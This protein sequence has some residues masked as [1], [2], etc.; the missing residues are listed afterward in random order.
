MTYF[1]ILYPIGR[2]LTESFR[3]DK[4]RGENILMGL[5][6]G[7]TISVFLIVIFTMIHLKKKLGFQGAFRE[8]KF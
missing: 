7:Q 5:S 3:G 2:F 1:F 8:A 4:F 6:M